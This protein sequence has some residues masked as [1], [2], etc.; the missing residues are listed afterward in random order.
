MTVDALARAAGIAKGSVY[1]YF[2]S[3]E[4]ILGAL[5]AQAATA[6]VGEI[7]RA[8]RVNVSAAKV[9]D[10]LT[11]SLEADALF[12]PLLARVAEIEAGFSKPIR[13][14][15]RNMRLRL[16][17]AIAE[18]LALGRGVPLSRAHRLA[19]TMVIALQG[20]AQNGLAPPGAD[21]ARPERIFHRHLAFADC[22]ELLIGAGQTG[23]TPTTLP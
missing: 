16:V 6:A 3:R 19:Q 10:G 14:E 21:P 22:A 11:E 7:G 9:M 20:A 18:S 17:N 15:T 2:R 8:V 12:L 13:S 23:R 4:E 5:F 1:N